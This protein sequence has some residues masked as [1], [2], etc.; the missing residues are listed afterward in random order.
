[1]AR[2]AYAAKNKKEHSM[3]QT[4]HSCMVL[5]LTYFVPVSKSNSDFLVKST[6]RSNNRKNMNTTILLLNPNSK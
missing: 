1:M 4:F 5:R 2:K 6:G 3:K